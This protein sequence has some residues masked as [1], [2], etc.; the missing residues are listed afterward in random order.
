M[1]AQAASQRVLTVTRSC[2]ACAGTGEEN[3]QSPRP[4]CV[5]NWLPLTISPQYCAPVSSTAVT[6]KHGM[7]IGQESA[8]SQGY[9]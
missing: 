5:G 3:Q 7:I 9:P 8:V 4:S 1:R 6:R 2:L